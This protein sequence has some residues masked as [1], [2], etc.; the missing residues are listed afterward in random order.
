M[1][2]QTRLFLAVLAG[3]VVVVVASQVVQRGRNNAVV[4]RLALASGAEEVTNQWEWVE[5]L[6]KAVTYSLVDVMEQ[7]DMDK[8]GE[9]LALQRGVDGLQEMTLFNADGVSTY[10]TEE[11]FL[12]KGLP[13]DMRAGLLGSLDVVRRQGEE[14]FELYHPLPV[15]E[16]CLECHNE[17]SAG[18]VGGVLNFRFGTERLVEAQQRWEG[19]IAELDRGSL[20]NAAG[21]TV[22]LCVSIGILITVLVGRMVARP[23]MSVVEQLREGAASLRAAAGMIAGAGVSLAGDAS[24]QAASVEETSSSLEELAS[25]TRVNADHAAKADALAREAAR[26][27][28]AGKADMEALGAAMRAI[29]ESGDEVRK[30][31]KTIDEIAFQTN[32]LALNAAVEAAR[33]GEAGMGFAVVAEEVRSLAQR[34]AHAA[35]ETA[36]RIESSVEHGRSGREVS[37]RVAGRLEGILAQSGEVTRLVSEVASACREQS[38]GVTQINQA[39]VQIDQVT[40]STA[41]SAEEASGSG[42]ELKSQAEQVGEVV[43]RLELLVHG[44]SVSGVNGLLAGRKPVVRSAVGGAG[45]RRGEGVRRSRVEE[46][47]LRA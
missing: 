37:A 4:R 40:Q 47:V 39:V 41:A 19:L 28:E 6:Q 5:T 8:F 34:S 9:L 10:S 38:E 32:L 12:G 35:R 13:E 29:E 21:T 36:E 23:L 26:S 22:V 15:G 30:I 31:V 2:L 7:G 24:Q 17:F 45:V 44:E 25:M 27:A 1:K 43:E 20:W 18:Q 3:V 42:E 11:R 14:S 16:S 46:V 33:A